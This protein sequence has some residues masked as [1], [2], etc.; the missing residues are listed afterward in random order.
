MAWAVD[1]RP[2]YCICVQMLER[3]F[4]ALEAASHGPVQAS[5]VWGGKVAW[6][7]GANIMEPLCHFGTIV[8]TSSS[9][10]CR[11]SCETKNDEVMR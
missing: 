10:G 9:S 7:Q 11:G 1:C 8:D 5:S 6:D 3:P 4:A 2:D